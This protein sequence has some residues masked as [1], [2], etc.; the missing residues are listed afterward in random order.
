MEDFH[1]VKQEAYRDF[2]VLA[3]KQA[4]LSRDPSTQNGA[5][6]VDPQYR[7][8]VAGAPN[9]FPS[10][11]IENDARW[12]RPTKYW[13]VEHAERNAIYAAARAGIKTRGLAMVCPWAACADCAR[14]IAQAG[15]SVL[16][17][18]RNSNDPTTTHAR[19]DDTIVAG[20]QIFFEAGVTIVELDPIAGYKLRRNGEIK[21]TADL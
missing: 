21:D 12:E 3:Y 8:V 13:Y 7:L 4:E 18:H 19:W 16:A 15:I 10:G 6:L 11:V 2:L 14:A 9:N 5:V 20:D 1:T 17:R